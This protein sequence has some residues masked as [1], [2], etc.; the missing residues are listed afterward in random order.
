MKKILEALASDNLQIESIVCKENSDYLKARELCYTLGDKLST[1][2][3]GEEKKL[4]EQFSNAFSD[5][6]RL[7]GIDKFVT[8]YRLGALMTMEVFDERSNLVVG[9]V[10][11]EKQ[12]NKNIFQ[13]QKV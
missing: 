4:F 7:H 10:S 11:H 8:G 5:E 2:L 3:N 12:N 9:G 6:I 1:T 13:Q